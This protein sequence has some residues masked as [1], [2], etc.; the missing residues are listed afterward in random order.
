MVHALVLNLLCYSY[1]SYYLAH[2]F[3]YYKA[4]KELASNAA[5][6]ANHCKEWIT[7]SLLFVTLIAMILC[8]HQ[9]FL[10]VYF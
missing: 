9:F 2:G 4:I 10:M 7:F 6:I 5:A 1:L 8:F 3:L